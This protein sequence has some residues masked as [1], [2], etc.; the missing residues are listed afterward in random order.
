MEGILMTNKAQ[1]DGCNQGL[2][3]MDGLHI[4]STGN[5]FMVCTNRITGKSKGDDLI[6]RLI[7]IIKEIN[8]DGYHCMSCEHEDFKAYAIA[9]TRVMNGETF[10]DRM[11]NDILKELE[12][13]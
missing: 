9:I 4:T 7:L 6:E 5:T 10:S 11:Y 1:C 3:V 12:N 13:D 2:T 8:S